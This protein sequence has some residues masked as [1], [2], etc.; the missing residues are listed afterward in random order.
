[1]Q[2]IILWLLR[3][4]CLT[5]ET[6]LPTPAGCVARESL[7]LSL[8]VH[9]KETSQ[10]SGT[11]LTL[12]TLNL[13][14]STNCFFAGFSWVQGTTRRAPLPDIGFEAPVMSKFVK[15]MPSSYCTERDHGRFSI[16]CSVLVKGARV[17]EF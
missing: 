13:S 7:E 8:P 11:I 9:A 16:R 5:D 17:D 14:K 15:N 12:T 2:L 6:R 4:S 10:I 1:M 3:L